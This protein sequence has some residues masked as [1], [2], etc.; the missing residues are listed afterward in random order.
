MKWSI[1]QW[2]A[3]IWILGVFAGVFVLL[4][5]LPWAFVGFWFV[6]VGP[7]VA[8]A[9]LGIWLMAGIGPV[10]LRMF[11]M[12]VGQCVLIMI[13]GWIVPESPVSFTPGL[14]A[15]TATTALAM[16]GLGS[17]GSLLPIQMT[18]NI[19]VALWEIVVSIGLI[20]VT[21]AIIR[22]IAEMFSWQW[23]QW[24]SE[25]GVHFLVFSLYTGVLM[26]IALLPLVVR[27]YAA[28][29]STAA[30]LLGAVILIPPIEAWTFTWLRLD[31]G[32]LDLFYAAHAGQ[33]V[34]AL[35]IMIPLVTIFPGVLVRQSHPETKPVEPVSDQKSKDQDFADMQ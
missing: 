21:L 14:A 18:W 26:T 30:L 31:G 2:A 35:A 24:A 32:D 19:R 25:A 27:S 5:Q 29:W 34:M 1:W 13:M 9:L 23:P 22:V 3:L 16:L 6:L 15:T 20:G 28:R 33:V 7:F 8:A 10:W 12:I 17:T 4:F 11:G